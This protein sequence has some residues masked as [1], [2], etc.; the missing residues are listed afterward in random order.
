ML[1][2]DICVY[3]LILMIFVFLDVCEDISRT[4]KIRYLK[5]FFFSSSTPFKKILTAY[6]S[7][8]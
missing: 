7:I 3:Y 2:G 1:C 4:F 5:K 8:K 6:V